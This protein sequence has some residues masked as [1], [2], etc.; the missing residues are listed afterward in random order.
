MR[1]D[2]KRVALALLITERIGQ[3]PLNCHAVRTLPL[4]LLDLGQLEITSQIVE[5]PRHTRGRGKTC[6]PDT[7]LARTLRLAQEEDVTI[8]RIRK[9]PRSDSMRAV[10]ELFGPERGEIQLLQLA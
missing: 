6:S 3:H 2:D 5:H 1:V 7:H 4:D 10:G 8:V 9:R